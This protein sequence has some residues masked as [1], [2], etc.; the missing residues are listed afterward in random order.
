MDGRSC[1]PPPGGPPSPEILRNLETWL[2]FSVLGFA[3]SAT[4]IGV[5]TVQTFFYYKRFPTDHLFLKITVIFLWQ[6]SAMY[7]DPSALMLIPHMYF[8]LLQ[9]LQVLLMAT[10]FYAFTISPGSAVSK[11]LIWA[12]IFPQFT[13]LVAVVVSQSL[14]VYTTFRCQ[15]SVLNHI[16]ICSQEIL[17]RPLILDRPD[18]VVLRN[19]FLLLALAFL[20]LFE[21][22]WGLFVAVSI[23]QRTYQN[24]S[25]PLFA[26]RMWHSRIFVL[27]NAFCDV[28]VAGALAWSIHRRRNGAV[29]DSILR[30]IILYVACTGISTASVSIVL[31]AG[32][33]VA[34]P[35]VIPFI[36]PSVG[37][38]STIG[39]LSNLHSRSLLYDATTQRGG[40]SFL[41]SVTHDV[42]HE[43]DRE[44]QPE[45]ELWSRVPRFD[46]EYNVEEAK[47]FSDNPAFERQSKCRRPT[48][49]P[50]HGNSGVSGIEE[51]IVEVDPQLGCERMTKWCQW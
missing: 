51:E 26:S 37:V 6:V 2:A 11:R 13:N 39:F 38:I 36:G 40:I 18:S 16:F 3:L 12:Q 27:S 48:S 21:A 30:D 24:P 9:P 35:R 43:S 14:F 42:Q 17:A 20:V 19:I 15:W 50:E 28:V 32:I 22:G 45:L 44:G 31:A 23:L 47:T 5:V 49:M 41:I 7:K 33:V 34:S 29:S 46:H 4:L 10:D 8:R 1:A 25:D